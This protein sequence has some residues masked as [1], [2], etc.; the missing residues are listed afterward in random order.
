VQLVILA[1]G[2]GRRFGG[3]KQLAPVGPNG[4]AI[5]DYTA[6]AAQSC[7]F[8]GIV[9][10]VRAEIAE[11][12]ASHVRHRW[13]SDLPV[14]FACQPAV[15]GT[16]Q[17]VLSTR[18][19]VSGP[20]GVAN[21]D[22]LYG[23]A[24]LRLIVEHVDGGLAATD[25]TDRGATRSATTEHLLVAYR[26]ARTVLS[27]ATV[28][29][30]LCEVGPDHRLERVVEHRVHLHDDG[31]FDATPLPGSAAAAGDRLERAL[32]SGNELVSMNLWG[33]DPRLFDELDE[34]VRAFDPTTASRPEL[35]LPDVVG[36]LVRT[37][38]DQVRVVETENRCIGITHREDIPIVRGEIVRE[39]AHLDA[40]RAGRA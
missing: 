33:F 28:T 37:G 34:A 24:A 15:P 31:S 13:P 20:F 38:R 4:E 40:V 22:D 1:A 26:L 9:L 8:S 7:G 11:E 14:D 2:H 18:P 25:P 5:M 17:A 3:L 23:E 39:I 12:V 30:G 35:L 6:R 27:G 29:R 16:A 21:A 10:V 36:Q 19:L 32:L